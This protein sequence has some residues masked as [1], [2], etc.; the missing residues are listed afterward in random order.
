MKSPFRVTKVKRQFS[1]LKSM[2]RKMGVLPSKMNMVGHTEYVV[3]ITLQNIKK[4]FLYQKNSIIFV[5][6]KTYDYNKLHNQ[7]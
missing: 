6:N 3:C 7:N 1:R 5:K 2:Q 4:K